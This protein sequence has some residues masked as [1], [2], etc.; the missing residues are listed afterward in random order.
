MNLCGLHL[1]RNKVRKSSKIR[2]EFKAFFGA[3]FGSKI[4]KFRALLVLHV[5]WQGSS[6]GDTIRGKRAH[7]SERKM[8]VWEGLWEDLWGDAGRP[9]RGAFCDQFYQFKVSSERGS[10]QRPQNLLEPLR[11]FA[12]VPVEPLSFSDICCCVHARA[13]NQLLHLF[14]TLNFR[15]EKLVLSPFCSR[16]VL[17]TL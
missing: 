8:A 15:L 2:G 14:S 9:L 12:P 13:C 1:P 6:R 11:A 3:K 7:N 10:S 4:R 16:K 17:L 5:F